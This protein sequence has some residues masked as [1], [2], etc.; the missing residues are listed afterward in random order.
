MP[1]L[2]RFSRYGRTLM[3][4]AAAVMDETDRRRCVFLT[5]TLP[6]STEASLQAI[7]AWS[8]W[9]VQT[10]RQWLRDRGI[11]AKFFGVWEWQRRGALHLH[12]CVQA[13]DASR[14]RRLLRV[15]KERWI[16]IL[17]GVSARSGVDVYRKNEWH[18]WAS[19]KWRVRTDAQVVE[20]SVGAYLG[21]YLSKGSSANRKQCNYPPSS[22]YFCQRELGREISG[23]R[24]ELVLARL[25]LSASADLW[26]RLGAEVAAQGRPTFLY[27]SPVDYR[28]RGLVCLLKPIEAAMVFDSLSWV[29]RVLSSEPKELSIPPLPTLPGV[30]KIVFGGWVRAPG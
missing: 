29:F 11:G 3:R 10:V 6:G 18:T 8:G 30:Y 9:I 15:W 2:T 20:K 7:S 27:K 23:R 5:G 28:L 12:L 19:E 1:F 21:K 17:D 14:A 24:Q 13:P 26:E 4:E 22:W 16:Q 25:C